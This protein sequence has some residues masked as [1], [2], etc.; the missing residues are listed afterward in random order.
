MGD[1]AQSLSKAIKE[2]K[3]ISIDY[4]NKEGDLKSYWIA[5]TDVDTTYR[6]VKVNAFNIAKIENNTKGILYDAF[7]YFDNIKRADILDHTTYSRPTSLISKIESNIDKLEWLSYDLYNEKIL[8]YLKDCIKYDS[9]CYQKESSMISSIDEDELKK[10][11]R[12]GYYELSLSQIG[13]LV[14][15]IEKIGKQDKERQFKI[16]DLALNILSIITHQGLFVAVYKKLYFYPLERQ[17]IL[18]DQLYFNY[19]F[20]NDENETYKHNLRRYVDIEINEFTSLMETNPKK[21][22]NMLVPSLKRHG[23]ELDERPY[24]LDLIRNYNGYIEKEYISINQAKIDKT[25][26]TPLKAFFGNMDT[27]LLSRKRAF[28]IVLLDE[29]MNVDQ[30]RVVHN[31]L[32]QPI[33]YVQGPPGT[34]KTQ[35]ILTLLISCFFNEQTVL[36]SSNNNKP[37]DDIYLKLNQLTSKGK[38]IPL[39]VL[40]LGNNHK[41]KESIEVIKHYLS[42]YDNYTSDDSKLLSIE[43]SNKNSMNNIN[44]II[45]N[46]ERR[47]DLEEEID[48]LESMM[49][50]ISDEIRTSILIQTELNLKK[51]EL[52][53]IPVYQ[54]QDIHAQV[55]K[56]NDSFLMWLFFTSIKYIKR[57]KEPKYKE[58][59]EIIYNSDED[60]QI[61]DLNCYLQNPDQLSLIQR[62]F[63]IIMTTNQS[64]YRLGLPKPSF[65]LTVIDEAGQ[66]SIGYALFPI[67]RGKRLLLVGD[68]NQLRPVIT[69]S[70]EVNAKFIQKHKIS[71]NY[72]YVHNS[73]IQLMQNADSISKFILLR[74]HYRCHKDI[75]DFSNKKY[76]HK[77][78][79]VPDKTGFDQQALFFLNVNQSRF[80]RSNDRN[81][82]LPEIQAIIEDIRIKKPASVGIIT[83]FRNQADSIRELVKQENLKNVDVG[84]IHTFQGDEK[85]TIYLSTAINHS[86]SPKT[87][88]WVKNNEELL[89]VATTRAKKE[90]VLVGD[91]KEI[92]R[93][94]KKTNDLFELTEYVSNKGKEVMLTETEGIK[95][96]NSMNFRQYNTKKEKELLET[97]NQILS[98]SN[99]YYVATQVKVSPFMNQYTDPVIFDYGSKAVFDFVIYLKIQGSDFPKLVIEL[100][101]GEHKNDPEVITR[102]KMK[103]KICK[104]NNISLIRI[105][106]DYTRR[107]VSIKD[108]LLKFIKM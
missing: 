21:A 4:S 3:W 104:E 65:D 10:T 15:K 86:T 49:S 14:Q 60:S 78:L 69:L 84:T 8:D 72:N 36:V 99:D 11:K 97:I 66:C 85:D 2:A 96:V 105:T 39:P 7:L 106:N 18:D 94:S 32:K 89:N 79:I 28:H 101:G 9:V 23:E 80:S 16:T 35:S 41:I 93:R 95:N 62:V 67:I 20:S 38:I 54:D 31:A 40:R 82:S 81:V 26:S 108:I 47:L 83:P 45:D 13:E 29:K 46:Y 6:R 56:A 61:R 76:Y 17:L 42:D 100:D 33:T 48:A 57:L 75:I 53:T 107:Y 103:E 12:K 90:F 22:K 102:D 88:D 74:Y 64:A 71:D 51:E 5:I 73:I 77:K 19:E 44:E 92:K 50:Y 1:I 70:P 68:Q 27:S 43:T 55:V 98:L 91:L 24:I 37:I 87:F 25:L 30:L 52:N 58:F 59:I 63:P 34:G